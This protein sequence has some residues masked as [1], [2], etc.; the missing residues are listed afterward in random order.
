MKN[1]YDDI[2][3]LPHHVSKTRPPMKAIDRAA[4]FSPFAAL[5]GYDAAVKET[6]RL[7]DERIELSEDMKNSLSDRL[8]II[9][10]RI[11]E[12]PEI[13]ITYFQPDAKKKGGAYI[14]AISTVKKVDEYERIVVMTDGTAI[15]INEIISIDGQIFEI[16]C[17]G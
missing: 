13:A 15:P 12:H 5:T 14:T 8:Q 6:A 2:I 1:E 9:A 7:T 10:D 17:N 3:N 4:Q 16:M 11:K